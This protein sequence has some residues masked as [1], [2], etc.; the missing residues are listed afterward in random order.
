MVR[1]SRNYSRAPPYR[2]PPCAPACCAPDPWQFIRVGFSAKRGSGCND[3]IYSGHSCVYAA[4]ALALS[5]YYRGGGVAG[6]AARAA[7]WAAVAKLC[8]QVSRWLLYILPLWRAVLAATAAS[9]AG[10]ASAAKRACSC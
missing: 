6:A 3:L 2:A 9:P 10:T 7:A 4:P 5:T 8:L 1:G